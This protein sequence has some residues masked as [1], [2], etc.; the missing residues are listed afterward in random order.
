[1]MHNRPSLLLAR[2]GAPGAPST[3]SSQA[4][5]QGSDASQAPS[6]LALMRVPGRP[7]SSVGAE[8]A[9]QNAPSSGS[10]GS[11]YSEPSESS[12]FAVG[13]SSPGVGRSPVDGLSSSMDAMALHRAPGHPS[14]ASFGNA[15]P[16]DGLSAAM[17]GMSLQRMPAHHSAL[18]EAEGHGSLA[19]GRIP[20]RDAVSSVHSNSPP[21]SLLGSASPGGSEASSGASA[22]SMGA[23]QA[24][25]MRL[26]V[27]AQAATRTFALAAV[28]PD[29]SRAVKWPAIAGLERLADALVDEA[30][31]T[32]LPMPE[33]LLQAGCDFVGAGGIE[34]LPYTDVVRLSVAWH[35]I[36][37]RTALGEQDEA[38]LGALGDGI[39]R[40]IEGC[41]ATVQGQ[42][43][44]AMQ[45]VLG[46]L[47]APDSQEQAPIFTAMKALLERLEITRHTSE[48][49]GE[50]MPT[51]EVLKLLTIVGDFAAYGGFAHAAPADAVAML[52]DVEWAVERTASPQDI[53]GPL[54]RLRAGIE[55]RMLAAPNEAFGTSVLRLE[56]KQSHALPEGTTALRRA[57]EFKVSDAQHYLASESLWSGGFSKV[58]MGIDRSGGYVAIKRSKTMMERLHNVGDRAQGLNESP[59][60]LLREELSQ[61]HMVADALRTHTTFYDRGKLFQVSR[62]FRGDLQGMFS[63]VESDDARR[64]LS[65]RAMRDLSQQVGDLH[66]QNIAHTDIKPENALWDKDGS[67]HLA[68]FNLA[69]SV[70]PEAKPHYY[71]GTRP[72]SAPE[73]AQGRRVRKASDIWSLGMTYASAIVSWQSNLFMNAMPRDADSAELWRITAQRHSDFA[74][75]RNLFLAGGESA[76]TEGLSAQQQQAFT[77]FSKIVA[78]DP[79]MG[80]FV[81]NS[82]LEPSPE[83]RADAGLVARAFDRALDPAQ[84]AQVGRGLEAA[85]DAEDQQAF[86][87]RLKDLRRLHAMVMGA[88]AA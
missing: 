80:P 46:Q 84:Q 55:A 1:M 83:L 18:R 10:S 31:S 14:T 35:A 76:S 30:L 86:E 22:A 40:A 19:L 62:L 11:A 52:Q 68:D 4:T 32:R 16:V 41:K 42:M 20:N 2:A 23:P 5:L 17:G 59:I 29:L 61:Q 70:G 85:L 44:E 37:E 87:H 13:G 54:N 39:E 65:W 49:V 69:S 57:K 79:K 48:L 81:V 21:E 66:A 51:D 88:A 77:F 56:H 71:Q 73:V 38:L 45:V 12:A 58:R 6:G 53:S 24:L 36:L 63:S 15:G 82:M 47:P 27:F 25:P 26:Q 50:A 28:H 72:Y 67:I 34:D 43:L 7:A 9:G 8:P 3:S 78:R 64:A 74:A 33:G 60:E 75:A